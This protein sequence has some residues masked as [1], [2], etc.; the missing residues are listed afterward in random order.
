MAGAG[1][2]TRRVFDDAGFGDSCLGDSGFGDSEFGETGCVETDVADGEDSASGWSAFVPF[3]AEAAL[4]ISFAFCSAAVLAIKAL[5]LSIFEGKGA[6]RCPVETAFASNKLAVIAG[7]AAA[8]TLAALTLAAL[9]LAALTPA[10]L[11]L[12]ALTLALQPQ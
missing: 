3:L 7:A 4:A 1:S 6:S 5:I 8:S 12:A 2:D 11:T 10:A 9:A